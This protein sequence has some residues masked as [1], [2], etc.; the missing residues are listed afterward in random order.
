MWIILRNEDD[1]KGKPYDKISIKIPSNLLIS[2]LRSYIFSILHLG[3]FTFKIKKK[4]KWYIFSSFIS[5]NHESHNSIIECFE[6]EGTFKDHLVHPSAMGRGIF[7]RY[8]CRQP[9]NTWP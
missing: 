2:I 1:D 7:T 4:S 6:L 5:P 9:D 8:G 3:D